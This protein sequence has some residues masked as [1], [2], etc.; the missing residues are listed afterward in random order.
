MEQHKINILTRTSNRPKYFKNCF[1]SV[2]SQTYSNKNHLISVDDDKTEKYVKEYTNNYIKLNRNEIIQ[3]NKNANFPFNYYLN[4]LNNNVKDGWIMY[5]DDDDAFIDNTSL[6]K[7]SSYIKNED[8]LL[9]WRVKFPNTIIPEDNY[10]GKIPQVTH[11]SMI[12]FMFHSK[13]LNKVKFDG[14]KCA[15]HRFIHNLYNIIK[16]K[17]W[18]NEIYTKLQRKQNMGGLGLRDDLRN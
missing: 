8:Q 13:Y 6:K 7:I 14:N 18:I 3:N 17:V 12:G 16:D 5:L 4:H 11:I 1:N 10:F 2:S 9:L 15:D